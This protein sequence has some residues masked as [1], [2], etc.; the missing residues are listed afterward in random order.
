MA[1][2]FNDLN[3]QRSVPRGLPRLTAPARVFV[4]PS[5]VPPSGGRGLSSFRPFLPTASVRTATGARPPT[6]LAVRATGG[7][8]PIA[9][10]AST[11]PVWLVSAAPTDGSPWCVDLAR[12]RY[13]PCDACS[14]RS[15]PGAAAATRRRRALPWTARWRWPA[16][17]TAHHACP[18]AHARSLLGRT[19]RLAWTAPFLRPCHVGLV[20][21]FSFQAWRSPSRG[22]SL[23]KGACQPQGTSRANSTRRSLEPGA[24]ALLSCGPFQLDGAW[25]GRHFSLDPEACTSR[26]S[27]PAR[28]VATAPSLQMSIRGAP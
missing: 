20:V 7:M 6:F 5:W 23:G 4:R 27:R 11:L 28:S 13:G 25:R 24:R 17:A 3:G 14:R 22:A 26:R 19:L 2:R 16:S 12:C 9:P 1:A 21:A 10:R 18:P 8:L 15:F